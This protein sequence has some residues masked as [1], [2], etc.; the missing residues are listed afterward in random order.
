MILGTKSGNNKSKHDI[1]CY[2]ELIPQEFSEMYKK[3]KKFVD[4]VKISC[5]YEIPPR[6]IMRWK[7]FMKKVVDK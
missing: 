6:E 4:T 3:I 1:L 7:N 2:K 5:Y